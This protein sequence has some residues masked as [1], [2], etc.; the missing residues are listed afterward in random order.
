MVAVL[1][2]KLNR[3]FGWRSNNAPAIGRERPRAFALALIGVKGQWLAGE[4][5]VHLT[6][7]S[8][9]VNIGSGSRI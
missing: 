6:D 1:S 4:N 7:G 2:C 8:P 9:L 3:W 5:A